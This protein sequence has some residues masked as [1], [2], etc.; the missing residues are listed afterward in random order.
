MIARI[1]P[2]QG[3]MIALFVAGCGT[4][5]ALERGARTADPAKGK[6]ADDSQPAKEPAKTDAS[7]RKAEA[8]PLSPDVIESIHRLVWSG[9]YSADEILPVIAEEIYELD[10]AG[11]LA[12]GKEIARQFDEKVRAEKTWPAR[13][14]CD[15]LDSL[16]EDLN[17]SGIIALQNAGYTVSDGISDMTER[18]EELGGEKS[19]VVGYCLYHGQDLERAVDGKGLLL[20]FGD[21]RGDDEKGLKVSETIRDKAVEHGFKVEWDGSLTTRIQLAPF[22]WRRRGPS[23]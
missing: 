20:T 21:I 13:T 9:F 23:E 5:G 2:W 22:E 14:T 1:R 10:D 15:R 16:F 3:L 17:R 11:A 6:Q 12:A 8:M 4:N 7:R 18:Y 19:G